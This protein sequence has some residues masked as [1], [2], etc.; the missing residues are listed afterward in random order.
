M[1]KKL[2][3]YDYKSM[4]KFWWIAALITVVL[5]M[6]GGGGVFLLNAEMDLPEAIK[7]MVILGLFMVVI[8]FSIFSFLSLI[9]VLVRFYKN[10]FTDEGYLTFTLPVKRAQLLNSKLIAGS[11][12]MLLTYL[13]CA[14]DVFIIVFFGWIREV[15]EKD[16]FERVVEFVLDFV[17]EIGVFEVLVIIEALILFL[18]VVVVSILFPFCCISFAAMVAKKAKVAAA[19][20]IYYGAN[21]V[22]SFVLQIF[23]SF[24]FTSLFIWLNKI[25]DR[26]MEPTIVLILFA[27]ILLVS[28][29]CLVLYTLQYWMIDR[30]LNL[31]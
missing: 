2:L 9:L 28:I 13:V 25:S 29:L 11:G 1:L 14:L 21:S 18:L 7:I 22:L 26:A 17:E 23:Y 20:G 8:S 31:S 30:K 19:I 12:V 5:A 3:K 4:M 15:F 27:V 6:V 10:F 24:G 16:F